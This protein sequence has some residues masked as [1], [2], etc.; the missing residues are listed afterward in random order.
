MNLEIMREFFGWMTLINL[1]FYM[2]TAIMCIF[3][4]GFISRISGA[5]FGVDEATG[6]SIIY[7]YVGMYKLLFI[8][9]NLVPW[10]ALTIMT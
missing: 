2:W 7:G 1:G 5:M 4:K 9:F 10:I 3:V 6:R 8:V